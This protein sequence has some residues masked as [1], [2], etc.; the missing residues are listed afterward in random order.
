M[1]HQDAVFG[2]LSFEDGWQTQ[3]YIPIF[4]KTLS[5]SINNARA[6]PPAHEEHSIWQRFMKHQASLKELLESIMFDYY[7]R[8]LEAFRRS[9][10]AEE[11]YVPTLTKSSEVWTLVEALS[12]WIEL[13]HEDTSCCL[14][15]SFNAQ[16]DEEHSMDISFYEDQIGISDSGAHWLNHDRYDWQAKLLFEDGEELS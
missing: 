5:I 11:E 6:F 15:I 16:W 3:A 7:Q 4:N 2:E 8:H 12:I 13:G 10:S 1:K 14:S 9:Y